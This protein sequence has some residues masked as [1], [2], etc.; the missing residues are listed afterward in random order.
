VVRDIAPYIA[1]NKNAKIK[2]VHKSKK[3]NEKILTK[4]YRI[5]NKLR[6]P[7][8]PFGPFDLAQGRLCSGQAPFTL[9]LRSPFDSAQGEEEATL[10]MTVNWPGKHYST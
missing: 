4:Q 8:H 7:F 9:R 10:G 6:S 2:K 3:K 1:G 5:L